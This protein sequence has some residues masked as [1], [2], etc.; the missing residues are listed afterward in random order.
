MNSLFVEG[1]KYNGGA[2]LKLQFLRPDDTL[3]CEDV[4]HYTAIAADC[5]IQPPT[6]DGFR[7]AWEQACPNLERCEWSLLAP[8][9]PV[10]NCIVW[11]VG[12]YDYWVNDIGEMGEQGPTKY[13]SIDWTWG[14]QDRDCED[15]EVDRFYANTP[16]FYKG[17]ER[18]E[19]DPSWGP[20]PWVWLT[21]TGQ[22]V[23]FEPLIDHPEAHK[24]ADVMYYDG[25][26]GAESW[27]LDCPCGAGQW[28]MYRSKCGDGALIEHRHNGIDYAQPPGAGGNYGVPYRYYVIGGEAP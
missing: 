22:A 4:V 25:F 3:I 8:N 24:N 5:G 19:D 14:N 12:R 23:V 2:D 11:S 15:W 18:P 6:D 1:A 27:R 26:H 28:S 17:D 13:T 21:G 20:D 7:T 16:Y 10:F 9:Q